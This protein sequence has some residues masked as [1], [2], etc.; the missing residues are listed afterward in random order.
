MR[1]LRAGGA[2]TRPA[3][4]LVG[5]ERSGVVRRALRALGVDAWSCD[6]EP[7]EDGA[8]E[9]L[10]ADLDWVINYP[11]RVLGG[12]PAWMLRG[13]WDGLIA[14]PD[15]TYLCASGLHWNRRRPGR[16]KLTASALHF[17]RALMN[18]PIPRIA[19]ENPR[20]CIGTHIRPSDQTIQPYEFGHDASKETRLWL[21][22]L[23]PLVKDP[24][25]Y[26][27]PRI[28]NGRPR[29]SNQTDSGQNRLP[30][31]ARRAMDR[32]RTYDGIAAAM[33]AQWAPLFS[34]TTNESEAT[35]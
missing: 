3:R 24:A 15:C 18:A 28:V 2:V 26:V 4:V 27:A 32:A 31:S 20:G 1:E 21:K 34:L 7:A 6:L 33:A 29:W 23:P 35:R 17:V 8:A 16:A 11:G 30:P 5:C 10:Q 12:R 14:F 13:E 22:N 9:H 19:I 25:A